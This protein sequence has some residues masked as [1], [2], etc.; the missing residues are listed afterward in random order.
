[1]ARLGWLSGHRAYWSPEM[2]S[3]LALQGLAPRDWSM[4]IK[5][6]T[7]SDA[8]L[9]RAVAALAHDPGVTVP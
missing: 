5:L 1:L 4:T 7:E 2:Q 3:L 8:A 6:V 9:D